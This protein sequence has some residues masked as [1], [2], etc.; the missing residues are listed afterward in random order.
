MFWVG[1]AMLVGGIAW[2]WKG[3]T[4]AGKSGMSQANWLAVAGLFV[5]C[6]VARSD[7]SD[8]CDLGDGEACVDLERMDDPTVR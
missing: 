7:A 4:P 3:N 8:K 6:I 2:H 1:A 5:A